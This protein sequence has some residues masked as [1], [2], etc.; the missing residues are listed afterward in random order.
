MT[1]LEPA[2]TATGPTVR[3]TARSLRGPLLAGLALVLAA[4]VAAA[5][6][7][8]GSGGDLDPESYA[9]GGSRAVAE[10]L[11]DQGVPVA[12]AG[13]VDEVRALADERT[14]VV[15]PFPEA[16]VESELAAVAALPSPLLVVG[17]D[18]LSLDQLDLPVV[19]GGEVEVEQRRPACDLPAAQQAGE[20]DVG[21]TTYVV[22]GTEATGCYASGGRTPLLAVP[23]EEVVLLGS[24]APLTNDLLDDR[25]NAALALG[26]LGTGDRVVWL[27]PQ[28]GRALPADEQP[29]L[30]ELVPDELTTGALWLLV[31]AG[32]LA[33]WRAR[34]LG[35]V[36]EEPLPVV[37][38]AAEVVEGRGRLYRAA[39]ARGTAAETL[40]AATRDRVARRVSLPV[41]ADRAALVQVVAARTGSS[42]AQVDAL[43][44][45]GAPADDAALVRLA[46]DLRILE[47]SLSR[48]VAGP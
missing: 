37:V 38:R 19:E 22:D 13:T 21:G 32:V 3:S 33:L 5:L 48:E 8:T 44:Y 41:S 10:V 25:G 6:T 24:G 39:G 2:A 43:L 36:V 11:R 18:Q 31:T 35:P 7:A 16:L 42:D 9:P 34:R 14:L 27:V 26:L 28:A 23:S 20:A 29:S 17:A 15:L 12:R 30:G 46:D 40:R 4:V 47:T 45:G 1:V